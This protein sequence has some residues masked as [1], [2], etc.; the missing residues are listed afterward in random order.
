MI[1]AVGGGGVLN[2]IGKGDRERTA[3]LFEDSVDIVCVDTRRKPHAHCD[4]VTVCT[5]VKR[6]TLGDRTQIPFLLL[7]AF[8]AAVLAADR[9][10]ESSDRHT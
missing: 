7:G 8:G 5:G 9:G 3:S 2:V 10:R 1:D 4:G 6:R